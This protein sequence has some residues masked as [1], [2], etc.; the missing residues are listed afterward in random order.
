VSDRLQLDLLGAA[1]ELG[2]L[3]MLDHAIETTLDLLGAL[4][5]TRDEAPSE[6]EDL[7]VAL[8]DVRDLAGAYALHVCKEMP[9]AEPSAVD[10]DDIF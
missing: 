6:V 9:R 7:V 5:P 4:H 8:L 3:R 1:P 10:E 2:T